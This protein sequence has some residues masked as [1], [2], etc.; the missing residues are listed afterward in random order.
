MRGVVA[1][2]SSVNGAG[3]WSRAHKPWGV[4][5]KAVVRDLNGEGLQR[6]Q[7]S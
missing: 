3:R 1:W 6:T 5:L 2:I 4:G 7:T